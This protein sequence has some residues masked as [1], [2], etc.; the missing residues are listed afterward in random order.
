MLTQVLSEPIKGKCYPWSAPQP[1][2]LVARIENFDAIATPGN[3]RVVQSGQNLLGP[4]MDEVAA[5]DQIDQAILAKLKDLLD[6]KA[7]SPRDRPSLDARKKELAQGLLGQLSPEEKDY[8]DTKGMLRKDSDGTA[9][10]IN[11]P[12]F[13]R[14]IAKIPEERDAE[15]AT[16]NAGATLRQIRPRFYRIHSMMKRICLGVSKIHVTRKDRFSFLK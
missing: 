15:T 8:L 9:F 14:L 2:V 3:A 16:E 11:Y 13:F 7:L 1:F 4:V 5:R 12:D 6:R 10:G